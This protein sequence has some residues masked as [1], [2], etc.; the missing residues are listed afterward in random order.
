MFNKDEILKK[1]RNDP[2]FRKALKIAPTE[3]DR[4]RVIA[5]SESMIT[6]FMEAFSPVANKI[7][8]DPNFIHELRRSIVEDT[9]IVKESDGCV[10]VSGSKS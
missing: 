1:M 9:Q 6:I 8:N 4:K 5:A 2:L 3:E 7:T 10:V